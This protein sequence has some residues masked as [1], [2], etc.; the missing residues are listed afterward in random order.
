[1]SHLIEVGDDLVEEPQALDS[2]VIHLSLGVEVCEAR[3]GG[4]H[5]AHGV[6]GLRVQLLWGKRITERTLFDQ[7]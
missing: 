7:L 3:D 4:E 1:V 5:H 2:L 6:V